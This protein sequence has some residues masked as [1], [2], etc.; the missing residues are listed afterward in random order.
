MNFTLSLA[1]VN[2]EVNSIYDGI[3]NMCRDYIT[4]STA[5]FSVSIYRSDID[6]ERETSITE[7]EREGLPQGN[8]TDEYFETLAVYR[9]IAERLLSFDAFLMHGSAIGLDGKAYIFTA[10]S[11]VG[12]TTHTRFW[13]EKYPKSFV[14]NGDKPILRI[15]NGK[16]YVCGT[17]WSGKEG[18]NRNTIL[19]LKAVCIL[20]RGKENIIKPIDFG[21]IFPLIIGQ[22]HRPSDENALN[23]TL[24]LIKKLGENVCFYTLSCNLDPN[25][26]RIAKEGMECN[27]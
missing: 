11:G 21:D 13:L 9:K 18:L 14:I 8:F 20:F 23:K 10:P 2:I 3:Y 6:F 19:P 7:A 5:D 15:I 1:G 24:E 25:A 22:T 27:E 26:A 17:P 12:K 4:D 16:F